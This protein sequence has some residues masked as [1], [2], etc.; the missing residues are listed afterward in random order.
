MRG[1]QLAI[2]SKPWTSAIEAVADRVA[3]LG[4]QAVE[5]P[6]RAGY[7]VTPETVTA[8]LPEAVRALASRAL[9]ICSVAAPL[10]EAIIIACG[11]NG[12]P[13]VRTMV[14]VEL[15]HAGYAET[16]SRQ[17]ARYDE[18]LPLLEATGVRIGVQNH[19]GY[20]I[21]SAI[22][23]YHLIEPYDP[24]HVCAILDMAHCSIAGEPLELCVDLLWQR[25][26]GLIN[27][28]SAFRE[29]ANGPEEAEAVYRT[30]WTTARHGAFSWAALVS[31]LRRR[32]FTGTFVLPAE[33]SS[34]AGE[35]QRMGDDVL[36]FLSHDIA[37][38]R[39]LVEGEWAG[40]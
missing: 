10:D 1:V 21:G 18:L 5:L 2:F 29:R 36:P 15:S 33:Y 17:R 16:I 26:P 30:H 35:P 40:T 3:E 6:I 34:P 19:S 9:S 37:Y 12:I 8:R 7:Q 38:L 23:L 39:S 13:I 24:R 31:E 22:G 4:A 20:A 27:F 11:E 14:P 25:M 32:N 28:K